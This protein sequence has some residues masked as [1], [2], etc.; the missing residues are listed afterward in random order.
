[1]T[2]TIVLK[3]AFLI[4]G[5]GG[6]PVDGASVVVAGGVIRE[7]SPGGKVKSAGAKVVDLHGKTL[8]P[9]LMDAHVH[10][11]SSM[12]VPSE[13]AR[14]AVRHGT[15]A[16]VSDPHEIAN[17]MGLQGVEF[18]LDNGRRVPFKFFFGAPSCV[19]AT[20]FETAG[21]VIDAAQ[22]AAL[23]GRKEIRYLSEMMNFPGVIQDDPE[24]LQKIAAAWQHGKPVDG[25]APGLRGPA[26]EK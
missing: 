23:L 22:V 11:E 4:D 13:F 8:L 16:A 17:V 6:E 19:P 1:M 24:V 3:N 10:V 2:D 5:N 20:E 21:H 9:G 25:H 7:V 26:L 18:M 14:M 12:L 15:V